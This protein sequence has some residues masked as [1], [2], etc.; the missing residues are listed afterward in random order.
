MSNSAHITLK[1]ASKISADPGKSI[2]LSNIAHGIGS[3]AQEWKYPL[4]ESDPKPSMQFEIQT[5]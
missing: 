2:S 1:P 4:M 3:K 5:G